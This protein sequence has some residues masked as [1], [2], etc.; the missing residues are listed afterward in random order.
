MTL[1]EIAAAIRNNVGGGLREVYNHAY[2]IPQIEDEISNTRNLI[3]MENSMQGGTLNLEYFMQKVD[4]IELDLVRFPYGGYSNSPDRVPH[5]KIPRLVSTQNNTALSYFGPP[6]F[7][8]DFTK[9]YDS[10]FNTHQYSRVIGKRPYIFIDLAVDDTA[11]H[12]IYIFNSEGN[13]LQ[14]VS[15]RGMFSDP[16]SLMENQGLFAEDLEF[17]APLEVQEMIIDRI[18]AKYVEYYR[19]MNQGYQPNTETDT[20]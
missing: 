15:I 16:N 13:N 20:K 12:D 4:N 9:Y 5:V 7:S 3:I 1:Q 18:T 17:P 2:S 6:D 8:L 19:K 14:E 11:Q 10:T